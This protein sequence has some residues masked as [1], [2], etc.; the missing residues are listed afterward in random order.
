MGDRIT[1]GFRSEPK[2]DKTIWLYSHW[3]GSERYDLVAKALVASRPRWS[4]HDYATRIAISQIV[5]DA[6]N[7]ETGF[8]I[9]VGSAADTMP[10]YDEVPVINWYNRTVTLE[11]LDGQVHVEFGFEAYLSSSNIRDR[12]VVSRF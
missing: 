5:G 2:Q 6:W 3:C 12:G 8:G 1:F 9:S 4:Q 10:D 11:S 7:E